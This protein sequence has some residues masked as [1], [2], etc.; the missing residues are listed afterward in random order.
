MSYMSQVLSEM[1]L[2]Y[3]ICLTSAT[4]SGGLG[5]CNVQ[6]QLESVLCTLAAVGRCAAGG[7]QWKPKFSCD[8]PQ[9]LL[10]P[11]EGEIKFK[12]LW[13][14]WMYSGETLCR[15]K[16]KHLYLTTHASNF[17]LHQHN[18]CWQIKFRLKVSGL[19][20]SILQILI[21]MFNFRNADSSIVVYETSHVLGVM[22]AHK[23][24]DCCPRT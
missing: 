23:C 24:Q 22:H 5:S 18:C 14:C 13:R 1:T 16:E 8:L 7:G 3:I 2:S 21:H 20:I 11:W 17:L 6:W 10:L 4:R 19:W 12:H 9:A 15:M